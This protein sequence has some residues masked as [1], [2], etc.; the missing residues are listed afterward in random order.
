[1]LEHLGLPGAGLAEL[2]RDCATRGRPEERP[3]LAYAIEVLVTMSL[4]AKVPDSPPGDPQYLVHRWTAQG[5]RYQVETGLVGLVEPEELA[6]AHRRAAAYYEWRADIWPDA[7]ADL[8]EARHHHQEIGEREQAAAATVR[9]AAI[10]FRR[11]AFSFLRRLCGETLPDVAEDADLSCD[12]LHWQSRAAQA[13][14]ELGAADR[15]GREALTRAGQMEDT[16]WIAICHERL[17]DIAAERSEYDTAWRAYF[18]ALDLARELRD[19]IIEARCYQG[20]GVVALARGDDDAAERWSRGALNHCSPTRIRAQE[21][22]INGVRQLRDLARARGDGQN[23]ERLALACSERQ[24]EYYDLEQVAGQSHL[25]IGKLSL[26]RDDLESAE[27]AFEA[28]KKIAVRSRDRVMTKDCYLQLGRTW[29]R[30][31][32]LSRARESYQRYIGLA[33]DMGDRPGTVDCYHQM[34]ELAAAFGDLD[35]AAAWHD[36]ALKLAEQ[37]AQPRLLAE[38]HC[39]LA[40]TSLARG[41]TESARASYLN[42]QQIGE[43]S[44]DPQII[45]SSRL[46]L[47]E[48]ELHSGQLVIAEEIYRDCRQMARQG[49]DQADVIKCQMGLA[50]IARRRGDY[51]DASHLFTEARD[52]AERMGNQAVALDCLIELGITA[53]Q[54]PAR[55]E[56][57]DYYRTALEVA[58]GLQNSLKIADLCCRLRRPLRRFWY[59]DEVVPARGRNV[60]GDGLPGRCGRPV[61]ADWQGR[62]G[63]RSDRGGALL[64]SCPGS[65]G[66]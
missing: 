15:L 28:A 26:R 14:G 51:D 57:A 6:E 8:L 59:Q 30:Q 13:Q 34:G 40:K 29:Q 60:R 37:L 44:G 42:S 1:M 11:G 16:R 32:M 36:R 27:T 17:A 21:L 61:A 56:A 7:V 3:G 22:V 39:Q 66:P 50:T 46:G 48:V 52:S 55:P 24:A 58:E 19:L 25:Q 5:L 9:A 33:D 4:L 23:A 63:P 20:L 53:E 35:S 65:G 18:K 47:A 10:L 12:L 41:D 62:G 45:V 2:R 31:G 49:H 54:G 64:P 38:A 43:Q